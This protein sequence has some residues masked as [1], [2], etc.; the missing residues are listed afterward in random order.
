MEYLSIG[1]YSKPAYIIGCAADKDYFTADEEISFTIQAN[2]FDG[3][4]AANVALRANCYWLDLDN[5][6][7]VLDENGKASLRTKLKL[8]YEFTDWT[9]EQLY[10]YVN[11]AGEEEIEVQSECDFTVFPSRYAVDLSLDTPG[12]LKIRTAEIDHDR[13]LVQ[14]EEKDK[15]DLTITASRLSTCQSIFAFTTRSGWKRLSI[16]TTTAS[17]NEVSR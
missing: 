17:I 14:K 5:E 2:Y 4:P 12:Q 1:D 8:D 7:F 13:L 11:S 16:P 10:L 6:E 15:S 3:L 9:P